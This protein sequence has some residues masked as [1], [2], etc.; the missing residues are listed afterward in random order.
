MGAVSATGGEGPEGVEIWVAD[1]GEGVS[2]EDLPRM[3]DRFWRADRARA[4][5]EGAGSGLGLA[6]ARSL[7][8]LH[9]GRIWAESEGVPGKGTTVFVVLPLSTGRQQLVGEVLA[10]S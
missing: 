2:P 1:S 6:I 7:V 5:G 10:G 3:F 4:H 9:G 8:Q